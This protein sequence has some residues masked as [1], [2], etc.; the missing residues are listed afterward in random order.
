MT[1]LVRL[2]IILDNFVVVSVAL[3]L[4]VVVPVDKALLLGIG[5]LSIISYFGFIFTSAYN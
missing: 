1:V 2:V 4:Q 3:S 5:C